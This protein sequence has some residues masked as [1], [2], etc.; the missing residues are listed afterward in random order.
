MSCR[1]DQR[2]RARRVIYHL[3]DLPA[4]VDTHL[5]PPKVDPS[6][7]WTIEI[8]V[9]ADG[10]PPEVTQELGKAGLTIRQAGPRQSVWHCV[11]VV[12]S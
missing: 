7:C 6:G 8:V 5:I 10:L 2:D 1:L 12:Q 9:D 11:A 3:T 4:V